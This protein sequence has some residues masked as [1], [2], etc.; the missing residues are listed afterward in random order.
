MRH[1]LLDKFF[2]FEKI[3]L[4]FFI[5]FIVSSLT[6]IVIK[7]TEIKLSEIDIIFYMAFIF[8]CVRMIRFRNLSL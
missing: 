6:I 4:D 3:V 2:S 5:S 7:Y 1:P 8:A